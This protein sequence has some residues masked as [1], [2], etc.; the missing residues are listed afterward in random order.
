[1]RKR[2][3]SQRASDVLGPWRDRAE[4]LGV[5]RGDEVSEGSVAL[6]REVVEASSDSED[7]QTGREQVSSSGMT[8]VPGEPCPLCGKK[9]GKTKAMY[10]AAYRARK[11]KEG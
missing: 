1:M 7:V 10:Q 2:L 9:V 8:L 6:D 11:G 5:R 3:E 4:S